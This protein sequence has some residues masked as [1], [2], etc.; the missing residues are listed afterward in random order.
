MCGHSPLQH[1]QT[2]R[3][4]R[5]EIPASSLGSEYAPPAAR[6]ETRPCPNCNTRVQEDFVFCPRCGT[7][8]LSACPEC[9]RAVETNWSNCAYCGADLVAA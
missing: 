3:N 1:V 6:V 8:L 2:P 4:H 5:H 7:E 9:H